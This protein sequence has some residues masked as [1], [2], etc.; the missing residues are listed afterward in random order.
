MHLLKTDSVTVQYDI[1][2]TLLTF[3]DMDILPQEKILILGE[4]GSG[5]T[6]FLSTLAGFLKPTTGNIVVS[7]QDIY[8]LSV[9]Q[10]D[11]LRGQLFGFVFQSLHLIPSLTVVENIL[12]AGDMAGVKIAEGRLEKL[13]SSLDIANKA[14]AKPAELSQG[15]QQRVVIARAL[16][17]SPQILIA[18]EP[19]SALD[20]KNAEAVIN[21]L[22]EHAR[23]YGAALVV[24][25]HD[26]RIKHRFD[27]IIQ[28][29]ST[30]QSFKN[31]TV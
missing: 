12:L 18:D 27:K 13:L 30:P 22:D 1:R 11:R 25:T 3:P 23:D 19:T 14:A 24:A 7:G 2:Q 17:H 5:K 29:A 6:S 8:N 15:Q 10:R 20:D 4:S 16:I 31:H 21:L 9:K 26:H 28:L